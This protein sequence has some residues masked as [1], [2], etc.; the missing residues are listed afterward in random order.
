MKQ[1]TINELLILAP[2]LVPV[3]ISLFLYLDIKN[4]NNKLVKKLKNTIKLNEK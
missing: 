2:I 1:I 3:L 4:E